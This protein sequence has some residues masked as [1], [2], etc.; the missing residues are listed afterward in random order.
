MIKVDD[1]YCPQNH[2]CPITRHCPVG[3]ISQIG[4]SAPIIDNETCTNCQQ[5]TDMCKVFQF[6][7]HSES[8]A[9]S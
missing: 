6:I 9:E 1:K 2:T 4:Y 3:A 5:C 8:I 7:D